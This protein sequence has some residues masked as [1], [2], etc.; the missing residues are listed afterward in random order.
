MVRFVGITRFDSLRFVGSELPINESVP[1]HQSEHNPFG[2]PSFHILRPVKTATGR[3]PFSDYVYNM[4][5]VK[6]NR[7]RRQKGKRVT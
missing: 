2:G 4:C 6:V 3:F 7:L 1:V 5:K